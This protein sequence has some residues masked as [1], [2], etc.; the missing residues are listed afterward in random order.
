MATIT[1][2][3]QLALNDICTNEVIT[4]LKDEIGRLPDEEMREFAAEVLMDIQNR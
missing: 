4:V 3:A 1:A 2:L